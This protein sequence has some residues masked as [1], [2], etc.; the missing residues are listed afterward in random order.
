M[1]D[2][3]TIFALSSGSP[4]AGV[5]VVRISGP[6]TRFVLETMIGKLPVPR[7]ATLAAIRQQQGGAVIDRGLVLFFEGP[8]SFTGEDMGEIQVHGGRAVVAAVLDALGGFPGLSPAEAGAFTRRAFENGRLDL[9]A[10][11]GLAD[12]IAAETEAQRRQALRLAEGEFARR[13]SGWRAGLLRARAAVEADLDFADEE[14]V[15]RSV[16]ETAAGEARAVLDDMRRLL[17]DGRRGE[18]TRD[19]F[20][21]AIM[22]PPNAGKSSLLNHLTGREAAIVTAV[23]GTTRD[24]IEVHLDLGG[25]AVILIDTAGVRDTDD[26]IEGEGIRRAMGRGRAADLVLWLDEAGGLPPPIE[27][28]APVVTI[29]TKTDRS[30]D[31]TDMFGSETDRT[32]FPGGISLVTGA[33]LEKLVQALTRSAAG[34]LDG[35]PALVSRARQ[36]HCVEDAA[37][38]IEDYLRAPHRPLEVQAES[39]RR[40]GDAVGRL[41]G[42]ID[43]EDVLG[44]IF[45]NF[46]V[47]K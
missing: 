39:L 47:G 20:Q 21:V 26:P 46:C 12:L 27:T 4:P 3:S 44:S 10:V 31:M 13:A 35:E 41:T 32:G 15:P 45:S 18:R 40:A 17:S 33:G 37:A 14:D 16:A 24:V 38:E 34:A 7:V 19:G 5:A 2:G 8:R 29:R 30:P 43:I 9:T 25:Q 36:R 23:P 1:T 11:E 22:G 6:A 42:R 28:T